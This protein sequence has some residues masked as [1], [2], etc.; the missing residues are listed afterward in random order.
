M[1]MSTRD[2]NRT[3]KHSAISCC[4]FDDPAKNPNASK[5]YRRIAKRRERQVWKK[6]LNN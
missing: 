2:R 1:L 6:N 3:G 4:D 5:F